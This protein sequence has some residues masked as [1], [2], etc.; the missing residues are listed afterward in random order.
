MRPGGLGRIGRGVLSVVDPSDL[1]RVAVRCVSTWCLTVRRRVGDGRGLRLL[2]GP[3]VRV[4]RGVL[5]GAEGRGLLLARRRIRIVHLQR[6]EAA[7]GLLL[8][9]RGCGAGAPGRGGPRGGGGPGDRG[10][11]TRPLQVVQQTAQRDLQLPGGPGAV[12]RV[13]GQRPVDQL[14]QGG[15][16]RRRRGRDPGRGHVQVLV[17]QGGAVPLER[18]ASGEHLEQHAPQGVDVRGRLGALAGGQLGGH[19]LGR[20]QHVVRLADRDAD[21]VQGLGDAEVHDPHRAVGGDHDVAR[22]DVVVHDALLVAVS[23][24]VQDVGGDRHRPRGGQLPLGVQ[25]GAQGAAG[26]L[27]HHDEGARQA[28]AGV[29]LLL[30]DIEDRHDAGVVQPGGGQGLGLEAAHEGRVTG[31]VLPQHLDGHAPSQPRVGGSHDVGHAPVA[32][33]LL[34]LVPVRQIPRVHAFSPRPG[35]V[36]AAGW[37]PRM[38]WWWGP[39]PG[40]CHP[41][42]GWRCSR[43]T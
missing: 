3:T 15:R 35:P 13:L 7:E 11:G 43:A 23:Q 19:V 34:D 41:G 42:R 10:R 8:R 28:P 21:V 33:G 24:G 16:H 17:D 2:L 39:S 40:W 22:L 37:G 5:Q 32:Q 27:L 4:A 36:P 9:S 29:G 25:D 38:P 6:T 31:Q 20:P 30:P 18:R 1:P 12:S 26:D 14:L